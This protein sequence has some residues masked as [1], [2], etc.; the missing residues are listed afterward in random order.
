MSFLIPAILHHLLIT[1][2]ANW[3]L[4]LLNT[5]PLPLLI[6]L[7]S[8]SAPEHRGKLSEVPVFCCENSNT[9]CRFLLL[10]L[11]HLRFWIS[12]KRR[13]LRHENRNISRMSVVPIGSSVF[14]NFAS[15]FSVRNPFLV[16]LFLGRLTLAAP[17]R[18]IAPHDRHYAVRWLI[19]ETVAIPIR[20][21]TL[22][23]QDTR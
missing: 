16:W 8:S 20:A 12:L 4:T 13:P 15:S 21:S 1:L 2:F 14:A 9:R 22:D 7:N 5:F 6:F 19:F 3:L 10:M 11:L 17:D 23:L 18:Q